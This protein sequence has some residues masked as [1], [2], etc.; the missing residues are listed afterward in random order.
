[1]NL[2]LTEIKSIFFKILPKSWKKKYLENTIRDVEDRLEFAKKSAI[3]FEQRLE[4][5]KWDLERL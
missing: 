5:L 2:V 1:V 4:N 3:Y